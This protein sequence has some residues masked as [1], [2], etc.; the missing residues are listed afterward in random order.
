MWCDHPGVFP[1]QDEKAVDGSAGDGD[2]GE[3]GVGAVVGVA[4]GDED[5]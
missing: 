5:M 4:D 3:Q 2:D 1:L